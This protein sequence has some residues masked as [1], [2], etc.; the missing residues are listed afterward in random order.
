MTD[1]PSTVK[2]SRLPSG[3]QHPVCRAQRG[4]QRPPPQ[5]GSFWLTGGMKCPLVAPSYLAAPFNRGPPLARPHLSLP[6]SGGEAGRREQD[7]FWVSAPLL[8]P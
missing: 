8:P 3:L 6:D 1:S 5:L 4:R 7:K 2:S